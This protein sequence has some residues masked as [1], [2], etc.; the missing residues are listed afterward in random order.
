MTVEWF[1][2]NRNFG[3]LDA[4]GVTGLVGL[5]I[6]RFVPVARL[7]MWG[8]ALRRTTGWPCP[9]CGLTR[10]AERISHGNVVGAWDAN[11]LGTIVAL[12]FV[13]AIVLS[14]LHMAFKIPIPKVQ[15]NRRE[16]FILRI[17]VIASVLINY[18]F[19]ILKVRF[20]GLL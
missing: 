5:L 8:C 19:V 15:V 17:V 14:L 18:L 16:A 4:L 12:L 9:S 20:P 1:P 10:V 7:P 13:M 11:P 3:F 2:P 6:A